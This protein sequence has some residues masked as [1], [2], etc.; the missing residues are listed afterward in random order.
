MVNMKNADQ[1]V[2]RETM[3]ALQHLTNIQH[4]TDW[5]LLSLL[6]GKTKVMPVTG[7]YTVHAKI[8]L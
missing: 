2:L 1:M 3:D 5:D 8:V 7:K 4:N 6:F